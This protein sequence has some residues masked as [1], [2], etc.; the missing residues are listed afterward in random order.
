MVVPTT[1]SSSKFTGTPV[2]I[3]GKSYA[4]LRSECASGEITRGVIK[5]GVAGPA[6]DLVL[7]HR[8]PVRPD[9]TWDR[10]ALPSLGIFMKSKEGHIVMLEG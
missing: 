1:D 4:I 2:T 9:G 10:A 7:H 3:G 5:A 6:H 8:L